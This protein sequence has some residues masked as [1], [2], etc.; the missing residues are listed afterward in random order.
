MSHLGPGL[1]LD[2]AA[3]RRP[4][5]RFFLASAFQLDGAAP[6]LVADFARDRHALGGAQ[7]AASAILTVS[8]GIKSVLG[9]SGALV[10]SPA[11]APAYTHRTGRRRLLIEGPA[12]NLLTW[13]ADLTQADW[14]ASN[15]AVTLAAGWSLLRETVN[16]TFHRVGR[17]AVTVV[18]G[19]TYTVSA[20]VR[21][22]GR[23]YLFFRSSLAGGGLNNVTFD[24]DSGAVVY[25]HALYTARIRQ[26]A[27]D[28]YLVEASFASL[29]TSGALYI[30]AAPTD[31][32][33]GAGSWEGDANL[34]LDI[35]Y[36]QLEAGSAA[37]SLVDGGASAGSRVADVAQLTSGAA[38]ALQ[39]AAGSFVWRGTVRAAS[40]A[41]QHMIG[42]PGN[43]PLLRTRATGVLQMEDGASS[44][45]I[46]GVGAVPG[47][48]GA[49][50]AWDEAGRA[51]A[52]NG[53]VAASD[54]VHVTASRA[55]VYLG[56]YVGLPAGCALE[57]DEIVAWAARGSGAALTAQARGWA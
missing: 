33:T 28:V 53:G 14:A 50:I 37:T 25:A 30:S 10:T 57:I 23:R 49:A 31:P 19:A 32:G 36:M 11:N 7:V 46:S 24:L 54:A 15:A 1:G 55:S 52:V 3:S 4:P 6:T 48:I 44:L 35:R 47:E 9:P 41:I 45:N 12:T 22:A 18:S 21:R 27:A 38:A 20:L 2:T 13:P 34:G 51:G 43:F 5:A 56:G 29:G 26:I 16:T 8:S 39:G 42:L 40:A 17:D